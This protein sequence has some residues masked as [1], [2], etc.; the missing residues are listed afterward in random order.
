MSTDIFRVAEISCQ[1]CVN[2][3]TKEVGAITGVQQ[4]VVNLSDKS[5]RVEHDASVDLR[6]LIAAINEAGYDDVAVLA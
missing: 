4:V 6:T 3:I 1:H 5:V 2:A